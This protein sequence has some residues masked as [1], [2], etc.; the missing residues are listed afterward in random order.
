MY[1]PTFSASQ[2]EGDLKKI[3]HRTYKLRRTFNP[4]LSKQAQEPIYSKKT[5]KISHPSITFNT[6]PVVRTTCQIYLGLYLDEKLSL[7]DDI[8]AKISKE[9]NGLES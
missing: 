9:I 3:S 7:Y 6:V 1:D 4:D 2:P 8:N 5:V